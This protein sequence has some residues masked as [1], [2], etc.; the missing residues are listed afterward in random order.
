MPIPEDN[1]CN[2]WG[3]AA[4]PPGK[5]AAQQ[6]GPAIWEMCRLLSGNGISRNW[7]ARPMFAELAP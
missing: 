4:A 2:W 6:H 5:M 1:R 7:G 3:G